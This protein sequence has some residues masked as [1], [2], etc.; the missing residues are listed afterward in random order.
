[1]TTVDVILIVAAISTGLLMT[2]PAL[3]QRAQ[4]EVP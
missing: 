3:F 4:E 1:M 2:I